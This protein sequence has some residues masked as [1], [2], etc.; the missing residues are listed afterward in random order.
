M[1]CLNRCGIVM[2]K[3]SVFGPQI[4]IFVRVNFFHSVNGDRTNYPPP[5]PRIPAHNPL[6]STTN[7]MK[8]VIR[9]WGTGLNKCASKC[10]S[11]RVCHGFRYHCSI[12]VTGVTVSGVVSD[13]AALRH[14]VT[15]LWYPRVS[16]CYQFFFLPNIFADN[17]INIPRLFTQHTYCANPST[18]MVSLPPHPAQLGLS[19]PP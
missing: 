6:G 11:N 16:Y 7:Y 13:F 15:A 4:S 5:Y 1:M 9:V 14:T 12:S 10:L 3:I 8:A 19:S 18:P 17:T 2:T